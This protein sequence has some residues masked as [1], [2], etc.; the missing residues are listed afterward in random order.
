MGVAHFAHAHMSYRSHGSRI[1]HM[2]LH[3]TYTVPH[4]AADMMATGLATLP[5]ITEDVP[6]TPHQP[7][8]QF[9]FPRRS[10]GKKTVLNR[11]FQHAWFLKW[12]F[13]HY[14]ESSDT[15]YCHTCLRMFKE[16]KA[17]TST[18]ADQAFV[19]FNLNSELRFHSN[20]D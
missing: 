13:L 15:V 6:E 14:K 16:K 12:P 20:G 19:S 11:S 7:G 17:K 1:C 18:K 10:F 9:S 8:P 5:V 3:T 4:A 2:Q